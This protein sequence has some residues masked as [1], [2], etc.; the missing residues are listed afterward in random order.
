MTEPLE[1]DDLLALLLVAD[2]DPDIEVRVAA[3]DAASRFRLDLPAW[4]T[5]AHSNWRI[6]TDEPPGSAAR[7]A[8]LALAARLPLRTLREHLRRM[9]RDEQEPDR[10]IIAHALDAA[11]DPSR[12]PALIEAARNADDAAEAFRLLATMPVEEVIE[13]QD[14]PPPPQ[15][16][17]AQFWRALVLSRLGDFELLDTYLSGQAEVPGLF[18]GS[19]WATYDA[20]ASIRPVPDPMRLHL[21]QV[22]AQL[23]TTPGSSQ[24]ERLVHLTTWAA[25]GIADAEGNPLTPEASPQPPPL[26][27]QPS[28][29]QVLQALQVRAQLPVALFEHR[30]DLSQ[31]NALSWLPR[32]DVARLIRDVVADGNRRTLTRAGAPGPGASLGNDI[33][34]LASTCPPIDDWPSRELV[35][36]QLRTPQPALDEEQLAWLLARDRSSRLISTLAGMVTPDRQRNDRLRILRLLG[37]AGDCQSGRAG[38][39]MRGAGPGS[40]ALTGRGELLHDRP[41][42]RASM[43]EPPAAPEHAGSEKR[44]VSAFIICAGSQRKSFVAGAGNVIR[45]WIGL[46]QAGVASAKEA[47]PGIYVPPEGLP[48]EVQLAWRDSRGEQHTDSKP[49][50]LPAER[51][52]R[53]SDCDLHVQVPPDEP[54]LAVEIAFRYKGRVFE[55]VRLGA[56]AI[57]ASEAEGPQHEIKITA[58]TSRREV[59]ELADS[60]AVDDV[61]VFGDASSTSLGL[62][63]FGAAGGR[64]LELA[65]AETA[66]QWLNI[67]LHAA[68]T[69]VVRRK[70]AHARGSPAGTQQPM[71]TNELDSND[72]DVRRLLLNMA[73]HGAGLYQQLV[74][75]KAFTDP[76]E[77]IQV[78]NQNPS[79]YAPLEFV[80]DGGYPVSTAAL[81][82]AGVG[83]LR[84]GADTCPECKL[85][86]PPVARDAAACICPFGFWSLR[87]IIERV[88]PGETDKSSTPRTDRRSLP[89][90]DSVAFG[91]S[92]LVPEDERKATQNA[93]K[94]SFTDCYLA[95]DWA[96]WKMAVGHHPSLLVMLPHHGVQANLDY[97]EIGDEALS[98]DIGK[99][100]R[101][102]IG[103]QYV[104]PDSRDPG[105]IV[106][107][108][109]CQTGAKTETGYVQMTL[110]IHQQHASIVLGTLAEVL[111]RHAAPVARAI[112]AELVA[113]DDPGA[114]FGTIMRRVRRRMLA[115]G[116]LMALCLVAL[117]DAQWRLT[118]RR[119]T[120]VEP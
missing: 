66:I 37:A 69:L 119:Q 4:E 85:P 80:Y 57:G 10:E 45:C 2:Q 107:M 31:W 64:R 104:N 65:D 100:S 14:V 118:P 82:A 96:E 68:E 93:L 97:L 109:G 101:G 112:V 116:H 36:E 98:E 41:H 20:I 24:A 108:L 13:A 111:G 115:S 15:D 40:V 38:S 17:T 32:L 91:S 72:P 44:A 9:A 47:I 51:T 103:P 60:P 29:E 49:M 84:S 16:R 27:A 77:R 58:Q 74:E 23:D 7:R 28:A 22:M 78:L 76:G 71:A 88:A 117:G 110:R 52:A 99:L 26:P 55:I 25:T 21:L 73:R 8:A 50:L 11:S 33:V 43:A 81:C 94:K 59:I 42:M 114:D 86:A 12:I 6:V 48:L 67:E 30:L 39:P 56:H 105:P 61:F 106:L 1:P 3:L 35:T 54:Y 90:I 63:Q 120:H 62:L 53:S 87:K 79:T 18:W 102:Q 95:E 113:V 89:I 75:Q 5:I 83:A 70:A 19:P 34:R 46:P 92:H